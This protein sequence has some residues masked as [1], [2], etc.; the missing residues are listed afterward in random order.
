MKGFAILA[1]YVVA[2]I[3]LLVHIS[4]PAL[5]NAEVAAAMRPQPAKAAVARAPAP[6]PAPRKKA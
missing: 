1:V 4:Q 5:T 3:A 6:A 2:Q